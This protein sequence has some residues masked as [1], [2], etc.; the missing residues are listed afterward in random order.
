[1]LPILPALLLLILQGP[2]SIEKMALDGRL[3]AALEAI[4]RH[5]EAQNHRSNKVERSDEAVLATLLAFSSDP[6]LSNALYKLLSLDQPMD[7]VRKGLKDPGDAEPE[8][9][10]IL[11]SGD[12]PVLPV[13]CLESQRSRDGPF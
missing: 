11:S 1:M 12:V 2:S 4:S 13:V 3:P 10:F 7:Q 9:S 8:R 6:D 5:M